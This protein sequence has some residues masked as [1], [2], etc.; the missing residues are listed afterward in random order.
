M[1]DPVFA[2][3]R[4]GYDRVAAEY[5]TRIAGELAHKPF[6]R[7]LLTRFAGM[8]TGPILDAG[9][10]PG[11]VARFL[12]DRGADVSGLDFSPEMVAQARSLNPDLRFAVGSMTEL[13][14]GGNLG[15]IVAFYAV[16]HIPREAQTAM[17]A[18]WRAA[19][20]PGGSAL[21]SFHLGEED[22]H[23]DEFFGQPVALDF[24]FFTSDEIA[25]RMTAAGLEI[26]ERHERDPYPE[27]EV[28]TR[29]GYILARRPV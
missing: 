3:L 6:D 1:S 12:S 8:V 29:R 28:A 7:E 4:E 15:G 10:G 24:L 16:I 23:L 19:L 2:N 20:R 18:N 22:R 17:F 27:H 9:C 13:P 21:V 26:V 11:H 5:A 14:A 25:A